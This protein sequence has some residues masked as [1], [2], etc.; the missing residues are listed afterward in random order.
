MAG[1]LSH[2]LGAMAASAILFLL[3]GLPAI[4]FGI[5]MAG[6]ISM[7]MEQDFDEL[8]P[9]RRTPITHSIFFGII[10]IVIFSSIPWIS[11][12][13]N[14]IS[15]RIALELTLAIMAAFSTHLA[16]DAFTKEGIYLFPKGAHVMKW[17][18][19]LP[20]GE[21]ETWSYWRRYH[22]E[23]FMGRHVTRANEDPILNAAI[24][25]P[26]LLTIIVFVAAMPP[27]A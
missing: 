26:S 24:S 2:A 12:S 17:I 23:R 22:I 8:S 27:P 6:V 18:R 25:I 3:F 5:F 20:K 10:W 7:I 4:S 9:T 19:G 15:N 11:A 14:M 13:V 21:T 1:L 16:I